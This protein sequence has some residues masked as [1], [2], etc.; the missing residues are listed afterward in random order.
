MTGRVNNYKK[1]ENLMNIFEDPRNGTG[2]FDSVNFG[3]RNR[4]PGTRNQNIPAVKKK[5]SYTI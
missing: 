1:A 5:C 4:G 2:I 3:T